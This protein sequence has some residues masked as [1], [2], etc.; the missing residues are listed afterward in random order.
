[1]DFELFKETKTRYLF[2]EI[3]S[4]L[5]LGIIILIILSKLYKIPITDNYIEVVS[6]VVTALGFLLVLK[7]MRRN[8]ISI[9]KLVGKSYKKR[10][11][12]EIPITLIVT[13]IGGIGLILIMLF[14]VYCINPNILDSLQSNLISNQPKLTA[15]FTISVSFASAVLLAPI[16]EEFI[17]RGVLMNRL[18][19]KYGRIKSIIYSSLVFF[20]M[21][22]NPNPMTL[23]LGISCAIL[24]YKYKSL[25][26]SIALHSLNNLMV[27]IRD[28]SSTGSNTS[29][30]DFTINHSFFI[31]GSILFIIYTIYV[32]LN[33]RKC[34]I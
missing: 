24:V 1:M 25:I 15:A 14:L 33:L 10:F 27:F 21:H 29:A 13:Y 5:I 26:P 12:F 11:I 9:N 34:R 19:N 28:L 8:K 30:R 6:F 32:Y 17:F 20:I 4:V 3:L 22:M 16:A 23:C 31:F 18:Y 2:I 7:F